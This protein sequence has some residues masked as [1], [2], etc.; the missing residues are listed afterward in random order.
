[1][2]YIFILLT[3]IITIILLAAIG[4]F[5]WYFRSPFKYPYFVW[6]FDVS[7]VRNPKMEDYI[8][9]FLNAGNLRLVEEHRKKIERWKVNNKEKAQNMYFRNHRLKQYKQSL[10]DAH[11]FVFQFIRGV[12]KYKQYNYV[13]TS[14]KVFP[15]ISSFA[16][17]YKYLLE[18]DRRLE[19]INHECTLREYFSK[20]QRKLMTKELRKEIMIRDNYTC[21]ICGKYMPDEVG[22]QIDHII[23]VS[24][25]GKTVRSNLQVL[26]SKCNGAKSNKAS[27]R[28]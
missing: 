11:A 27:D 26:C 17:D 21:Q 20:E 8:D 3:L 2:F 5:V 12:T 13:R 18:R 14:Y 22:L 28:G 19:G 1:M 9:K 10:D 16:C 15:A 24:K 23:P 7:N 6:K 25:G 4:F